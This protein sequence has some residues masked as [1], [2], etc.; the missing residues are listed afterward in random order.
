[1]PVILRYKGYA[2]F[3]VMYDLSEPEHVHVRSERREAK[4]WLQ[5]VELAWNRGYRSHELTEIERIIDE[6]REHILKVWND[7]VQKRR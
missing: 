3:F 1:M 6:N 2:L 7:E 5:P 4:Y